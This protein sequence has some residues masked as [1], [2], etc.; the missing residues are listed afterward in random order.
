MAS[1][2]PSVTVNRT[3]VLVTG[4]TDVIDSV[5]ID[6]HGRASC[7]TRSDGVVVMVYANIDQHVATK[8]ANRILF[9]DDYGETWTDPDKT[10]AGGDVTGSGTAGE[11]YL[12][13]APSGNLILML[14]RPWDDVAGGTF[15]SIS[16]DG[17]ETWSAP[18]AITVTGMAG[19]QDYLA[20]IDDHFIYDGTIYLAGRIST[21]KNQTAVKTVFVKSTDNG[22]NWVYVS[23]ITAGGTHEVGIEYLG[24]NRIIAVLRD[25]AI[26]VTYTAVSDDMGATWSTKAVD[27]NLKISGRH[28]IYTWTHLQGGANWW[29]DQR[30]IMTG[31]E[32]GVG[33][34]R[35]LVFLSTDGGQSWIA[36]YYVDTAY[37]DAGYGDLFY[38]P[39]TDEVVAINYRGTTA[40]AD[41]VQ[42][43]VTAGWVT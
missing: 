16:T 35:N 34:R 10:L 38:N 25:A 23:D 21:D 27:I 36:P 42:Y 24:N 30:L 5:D 43:N 15:Q 26:L 12:L 29:T 37:S 18:S 41:L 4:V 3:Q 40:A 17:G 22:A 32:Q 1:P 7:V 39:N 13:D 6:W 19:N 31:F 20:L 2:S 8:E 11:P 33:G 9:S 28:R 14:A